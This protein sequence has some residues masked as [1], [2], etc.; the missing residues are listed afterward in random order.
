MDKSN[1]SLR[2]GSQQNDAE[3]DI[4]SSYGLL[5]SRT[6]RKQSVDEIRRAEGN[7]KFRV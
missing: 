1:P 4:R 5:T 2:H 7:K 3:F 6:T